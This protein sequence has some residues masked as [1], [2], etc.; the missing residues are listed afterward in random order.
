MYALKMSVTWAAYLSVILIEVFAFMGVVI[1]FVSNIIPRPVHERPG[2]KVWPL[3]LVTVIYV[4]VLLLAVLL[5]PFA[6]NPETGKPYEVRETVRLALTI[7]LIASVPM[8]EVFIVHWRNIK[9]VYDKD[10][11]L[12]K[13]DFARL[14]KQT[15]AICV[16]VVA[17]ILEVP[18]IISFVFYSLLFLKQLEYELE[19]L[20]KAISEKMTRC[21]S[22]DVP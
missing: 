9:G 4:I 2:R 3:Y 1:L 10:R 6:V 15:A 17:V 22:S 13:A 20:G 11:D 5:L 21:N 7:L 14:A 12:A 18:A 8:M 19:L 16:G